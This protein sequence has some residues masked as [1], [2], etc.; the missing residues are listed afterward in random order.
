M[1]TYCLFEGRHELP[2]NEGA[3]F[4]EF[5]FETFRGIK[6]NNYFEALKEIARGQQVTVLVTGLTPALTE[7]I[8][9]AIH[10]NVN[11]GSLI[12]LHYNSEKKKYQPQRVI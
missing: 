8:S 11:Q 9:D 5:D 1:R 3:L 4:L 12:L 7:F 10:V 6:T 2:E